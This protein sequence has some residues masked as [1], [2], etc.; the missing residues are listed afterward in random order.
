MFL[1]NLLF[2]ICKHNFKVIFFYCFCQTQRA[3]TRLLIARKSLSVAQEVRLSP[4]EKIRFNVIRC[5]LFFS[6]KVIILFHFHTTLRVPSEL[7]SVI[8]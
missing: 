5:F 4:N 1:F 7:Y 6:F 8:S 3:V 2:L